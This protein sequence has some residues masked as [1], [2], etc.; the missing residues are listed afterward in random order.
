[1]FNRRMAEN[2]TY[3]DI[4]QMIDHSLVN[5]TLTTEELEAGIAVALAY[6]TAT[7][8]I[9]PHYL[10]RCVELLRDSAVRPGT[11]VGFPHGSQTVAA[12]L[13]EA[14]EAMRAGAVE[15]D[16]VANIS[17]ARGGDW[18][19]L[20]REITA[21]CRAAHDGGAR[22]KVIFENC[23]L[24]TAAKI[25]LCEICGEAGVD[26]VK[27]STGFGSGGATMEDLA[28]MRRHCPAA[29]GVK[30]AGGIRT[31]AA[32]LEARALGVSRIGA[33][34]TAAILDACRQQ[35]GLPPIVLAAPA[36]AVAAT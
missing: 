2:Y 25:R 17:R 27:T 29:V 18:A 32:L 20:A 19:Y 23:Y 12:K 31:W 7:V 3:P 6:Q 16:M 5:P 36:P 34:R 28:L 4:A 24:D 22:L 21:L 30:A 13:A 1:M 10:P 15:L 9:V 11:T 26:W 14:G 8:C 35:L 33:T